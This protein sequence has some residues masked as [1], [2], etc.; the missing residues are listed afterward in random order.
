MNLPMRQV[1]VIFFWNPYRCSHDAN[2]HINQQRFWRG[3]RLFPRDVDSGKVSRWLVRQGPVFGIQTNDRRSSTSTTLVPQRSGFQTFIY[4][5]FVPRSK[6]PNVTEAPGS[7]LCRGGTRTDKH[8][9]QVP[10]RWLSLAYTLRQ[11]PAFHHLL[12]FEP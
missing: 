8:P 12:S 9:R 6:P 3:L 1:F 10:T 11:Q 7:D 2:V 5:R 4:N